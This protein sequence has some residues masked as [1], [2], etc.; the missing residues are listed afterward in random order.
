MAKKK[1]EQTY[2]ILGAAIEVHKTLGPGFLE[3]VYQEALALEF[4]RRGI[5]FQREVQLTI[6]YKG[7]K[8]NT[9]YKTDF[10][11]FNE[12]IVELKAL[13]MISV[14]EQSQVINYLKASG[15]QRSLLLNFE[16]NSLQYKRLVNNYQVVKSDGSD[17]RF[18]GELAD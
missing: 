9:F 2:A 16:T 7:Q 12:I 13:D 6:S 15:L 11:C 5:P 8:L 17:C 10:I 4:T 1:D 18:S 3:P 14:L